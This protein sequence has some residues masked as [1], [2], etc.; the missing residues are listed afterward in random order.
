MRHKRATA[1]A[2]KKRFHAGMKLMA[3]ELGR[4]VSGPMLSPYI[5]T[6]ADIV[7][8]HQFVPPV[9]S[10]AVFAYG[11]MMGWEEIGE[12]AAAVRLSWYKTL[13][14]GK[15]RRFALAWLESMREPWETAGGPKES[16]SQ[17]LYGYGPSPTIAAL[18]N[19]KNTILDNV[20][21]MD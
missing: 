12:W 8:R 15:H 20:T 13:K 5:L 2:V 16:D 1:T 3:Q 14:K 11:T 4:R 10:D 17:W 9:V 7:K 21:W 18:M 19:E 6:I